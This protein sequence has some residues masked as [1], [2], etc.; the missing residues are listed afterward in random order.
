[1]MES[2]D[3]LLAQRAAFAAQPMPVPDA[4]M[5]R[6]L[7]DAARQQPRPYPVA[8]R[9]IDPPKLTFWQ[10]VSDLFGGGGVLAGLAT[11][12]CAGIYLGAVQPSAITAVTLALVGSSAVD[13]LDFMP[14]IDS[15]LAEE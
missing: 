13:Q 3:D 9:H 8:A 10:A 15:L 12:A 14:S 4:L 1:M 2:L 7:A 11:A 6:I 5:A